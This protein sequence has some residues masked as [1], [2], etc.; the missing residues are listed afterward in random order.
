MDAETGGQKDRRLK[1]DPVAAI[2]ASLAHTVSLVGKEGAH[3]IVGKRGNTTDTFYPILDGR[4]DR[5]SVTESFSS[6]RNGAGTSAQYDQDGTWVAELDA[7]TTSNMWGYMYRSIFGFN[8]S[9]LGNDTINSA[10]F[11]LYGY[12]R[13]DQ[14]SQSITIHRKVPVSESAIT[15]ADYS[16][17]DDTA[18]SNTRISC[19]SWSLTGYNN[20]PLN[21]AGKGNINN[22]SGRAWFGVRVS[23]DLDNSAPTWSSNAYSRAATYFSEDTTGGGG[24]DRDPKLVVVHTSNNSAPTPPSELFTDGETN[25][26]ELPTD[27]PSFS[28][29]YNDPD[30]GDRPMPI[31][32]RSPPHPP[33]PLSIGTEAHPPWLP[34]RRESAV[35]TSH[36]PVPLL[37]PL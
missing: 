11:S 20:F 32:S 10:T 8:T 14:L 24:T 27:A 30:F 26:S 2:R 15:T 28:A 21:T 4:S 12:A 37:P 1:E 13:T 6:L 16:G 31:I 18:Q 9:A 29:I 33:S 3:I 5:G 34:R 35:R 7:R 25:P 23:A 36:M 22:P 17:W 19:A